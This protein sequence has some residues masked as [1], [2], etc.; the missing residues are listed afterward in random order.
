MLRQVRAGTG[1]SIDIMTVGDRTDIMDEVGTGRQVDTARLIPISGQDSQKDGPRIALLTPYTGGNYGDGAIQD[2]MI[3]NMRLR[4]P[5]AQFSGIALNCE[6]FLKWHGVGAFAV[7]ATG[8]TL[9]GMADGGARRFPQQSENSNRPKVLRGVGRWGKRLRNALGKTPVLG[10]TLRKARLWTVV[11]WSEIS[12]SLRGYRFVRTQDLVV[13]SGGGQLDEEWG[14]PWGHPFAL[15]KWAILSRLARVPFVVVSVGAGKLSS[16]ISRYFLS[17]ALRAAAYR[18]YRD[19]KSREIAAG[20]RHRAGLDPVVPDLAFS[21]PSSELPSSNCIRKIAGGR[22]IFA[23]SPMAFAKPGSWPFEDSALYSRYLRRIASVISQ[24]LE[25]DGFLVM[26]WS[27][28]TDQKVIQEI[29]EHLDDRS[30]DRL[31]RQ[32][33]IPEIA[34]WR[35]LVAVLLDV[36]F[37][38]AS[39]LHSTILGFVALCPTVAISFDPKVDRVMEELGQTDSLLQI[40]DFESVEVIEALDG[41]ESRRQSVTEQIRS[42]RRRVLSEFA[43]QYDAIAGLTRE[44]HPRSN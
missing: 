17:V 34:S 44:L 15:F 10:L 36:D 7:C 5:T 6:N 35:D 29:F 33:H 32:M 9:Y 13:V 43:M 11:A 42:H 23:V 40:S 38:V 8:R 22:K 25:R 21:L 19:K 28:L 30:K 27:T 26:V 24:L 14:G 18:S 3:A 12:H 2:A 20:L 31:Q 37:L 1:Q 41:L 39:R 4:F 16:G